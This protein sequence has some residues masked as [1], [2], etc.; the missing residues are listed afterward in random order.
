MTT[1]DLYEVLG[2]SR[3]AS[4]DEIKSA[5]RR[6]ARQFH[7][8][9]NPDNPEAEEQ[10]KEIGHAYNI[11][12]D[13]DKRANYDRYGT[14]DEMPQ[15]PFFSGSASFT[16]IFDMFFGGASGGGGRA[17]TAQNG[18]DLHTH[19]DISLKE[20]V[21]GTEKRVRINKLVSCSECGGTGA[22]GGAQPERCKQCD[23]AGVVQ[24]IQNTF[25]GQVRTSTTCPVC[26]GQGSIISNPCQKCRGRKQVA[27][28]AELSVGVPPGVENGSTMRV[29]G[30]GN[31]GIGGGR[32]GDLYVGI[33]VKPDPRFERDG[34]HLHATAEVTFAQAAL[35]DEI[36]VPGIEDSHVLELPA[37]TQ[38]GQVLN[39]RG[40]GLPP[41]HGGR[42]GDIYAHV[43]VSVPKKLTDGQKQLLLQFAEEGGETIPKGDKGGLLSG[44]FKKK[45]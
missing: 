24:R 32:P 18:A 2:V 43:R 12:S 28:Q 25:I 34:Q 11:L 23:G 45:R 10:F 7:P 36:T 38:P 6:L 13:P 44:L 17:R 4:Q 27:E 35:G 19:V 9:V 15:D 1:R 8:D 14:V 40:A 20:V 26:N 41:L 33:T 3:E 5:Y 16:D 31:E 22:E 39:V 37:G 29:P 21:D 30:Q 42:R